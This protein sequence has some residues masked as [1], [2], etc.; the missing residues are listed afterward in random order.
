MR[1][2]RPPPRSAP[3]VP[4]HQ[5][6]P[7]GPCGSGRSGTGAACHTWGRVKHSWWAD[8]GTHRGAQGT[9]NSMTGWISKSWEG[10][11]GVEGEKGGRATS[12][13]SKGHSHGCG[14]GQAGQLADG[15][16][17][18]AGPLGWGAVPEQPQHV[19]HQH[20]FKQGP[21]SRPPL[22]LR[23]TGS[24]FIDHHMRPSCTLPK[25][26]WPTHPPAP[27]HRCRRTQSTLSGTPAHPPA[28]PCTSLTHPPGP[29]CLC[30]PHSCRWGCASGP[31]RAQRPPPR[32]P[33]PP[34]RPASPPWAAA[35]WR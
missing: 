18:D 22:C 25:A 24:W 32:P 1:T 9:H 2:T 17:G 20:L 12:P 11:I 34:L 8:K 33:P 28:P 19:L 21:W 3:A 4:L 15:Q 23:I 26:S 10:W 14:G 31:T 30:G 7:G 13:T 29:R 5:A 16:G 35:S 27:R 6:A